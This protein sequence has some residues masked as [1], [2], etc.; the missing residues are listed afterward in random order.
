MGT[1]K[2]NDNELPAMIIIEIYSLLI[3]HWFSVLAL[4]QKQYKYKSLTKYSSQSSI[5]Y[6][7]R[8]LTNHFRTNNIY[9]LRSSQKIMI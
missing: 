7:T 6:Y 3:T 5:L 9:N 8:A 4:F 1:Y 2:Y